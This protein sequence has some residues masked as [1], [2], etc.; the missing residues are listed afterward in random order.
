[1]IA[2]LSKDGKGVRFLVMAWPT[3]LISNMFGPTSSGKFDYSRKV[4]HKHDTRSRG[5]CFGMATPLYANI[6]KLGNGGPISCKKFA[7]RF[8]LC[9]EGLSLKW[10]KIF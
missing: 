2:S 1:M 7:K 4:K 5:R 6:P 8:H 9:V 3:P 10:F